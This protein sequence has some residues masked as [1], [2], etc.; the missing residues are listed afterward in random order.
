MDNTHPTKITAVTCAMLLALMTGCSTIAG[1]GQDVQSAGENIE[2]EAD[3][4]N[5]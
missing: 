4:H 2:E 3:D 5:G 1:F